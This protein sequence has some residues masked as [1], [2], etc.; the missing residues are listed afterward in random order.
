[1][2]ETKDK[3]L[4]DHNDGK[5]N[6]K[7]RNP[8][9]II[10]AYVATG[11]IIPVILKYTVFENPAESLLSNDG[12]ASFLGG[13]VGGVLGGL[14]TLTAMY[15]TIKQSFDIQAENKK[16]TDEKIANESYRRHKEY[17]R[18][19]ADRD[20][21][22]KEEW[23]N[24]QKEIRR[25]LADNIAELVGKYITEISKYHYSSMWAESLDNEFR[26][27]KEKYRKA[28]S[29][30]QVKLKKIS[31]YE[32]DRESDEYRKLCDERDKLAIKHKSCYRK[33]DE[34]RQEVENNRKYGDRLSA[35]Q[36]FFTMRT[37]LNGITQAEEFLALLKTTHH[38]SGL[39]N[40]DVSNEAWPQYVSEKLMDE[41]QIFR[42][43]YINK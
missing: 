42:E 23:D 17:I 2:T 16:D 39:G 11:M 15:F 31:E 9:I 22:R 18:D 4:R 21:E 41:Y 37:K 29:E 24:H 19:K 27:L 12:W 38:E 7:L 8:V 43:T 30:Y 33:Y 40:N 28:D 36:A 25:Q 3:K 32:G 14:G 10:V 20:A 34:K 5:F 35:N 1:M 13:Y 6:S 26:E